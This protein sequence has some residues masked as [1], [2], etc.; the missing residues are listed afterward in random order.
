MQLFKIMAV[1]ITMLFPVA[2]WG[3]EITVVLDVTIDPA[4]GHLS[5]NAHLYGAPSGQVR[6]AVD[7]LENVT[8]DGN[9]VTPAPDDT[10]V[11]ATAVGKST[12]IRYEAAFD[13]AVGQR[14]GNYM[15]ARNVFLMAGW[16]PA[17]REMARYTLSVTLPEGFAAVS[18]AESVTTA[19]AGGLTTHLFR[20]DHPL[21]GLHLAASANYVVNKAEHDGIS[22]ET[23][24]FEKDAALADTYIDATRQYLDFYNSTLT[25]YPYRRFAIVENM[26]PTGYSMPTFTL[27]GKQVVKLPFI[28]KTS[29]AH[30]IVHQWFGNYVYIDHSQGNWAEG[31]TTYLSDYLLEEKKGSGEAYRKRVLVEYDAYVHDDNAMAVRDFHFRGNKAQAAVGYGRA[32]MF[33][34]G[35]RKRYGDGLF[36]D[37]LKDVIR[38]NRF[39]AASW[40]DIRKSF[41]KR[42]GDTLAGYFS[43][44]LERPDIPVLSVSKGGVEIRNGAPVLSFTLQQHTAPFPLKVPIQVYT[45]TGVE[46][47]A[48]TMDKKQQDFSLRLEGLPAKVV[49]DQGNDLMRR[50]T[51][52]EMP[53]VLAHIMGS[54]EL[55]FVVA[56][57]KLP[58][59]QPLVRA[60][61][62]PHITTVAPDALSYARLKE[63]SLVV[64]GHDNPLAASLFG[65]TAHPA[66]TGLSLQ[67]F[68]NPFSQ[69]KR[70]LVVHAAG[71]KETLAVMNNLH[72]YGQYSRLTFQGGRVVVKKT[73]ESA[74]GIVIHRQP[75]TFALRPDR[76]PTLGQILDRLTASRVVYVGERHDRHAHHMNQLEII[77]H[78]YAAGVDLAVG[79][80]MFHQPFQ[81]AVNR[82]LENRTDE[83]TFLRE[84]GYYREWGYDYGLY[85]PIVDFLKENHI[86]LVALNIPGEVS[87]KVAREGIESLD[88]DQRAWIP[89]GL[90]FSNQ[91]YRRDLKQVY[92]LHG[93]QDGINNFDTFL[94]AQVLWDEGMADRAYR[95][96][97]GHPR[98]TLVVLAGNGHLRHGYGIPQR[99]HRRLDAP[100]TVI[101]QD[102]PLEAGIADYV[103]VTSDVKG[104]EA[105]KLGVTVAEKAQG[106]TITG[107]SKNSPAEKAGLEKGDLIR[108]LD[109][110]PVENLADLRLVLFYC[111]KDQTTSIQVER[112]EQ[113]VATEITL[114]EFNA[115]SMHGGK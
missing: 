79:M 16:Y 98:R 26:L 101:V 32:A 59:Y 28:V 86:P 31:L 61:G 76:E 6:L 114:F 103:L 46:T 90:D 68:K 78:L 8:V 65:K 106:L 39:R 49:L 19:S 108:S 50:L 34:H 47:T 115:F 94:Q 113:M 85:K 93:R 88:D 40:T 42:S 43:A 110:Q 105:P 84:S 11:V 45:Q 9:E 95:Y 22:I 1:F 23:Y 24:F 66:D 27:L 58:V 97:E 15:D 75:T 72:H 3:A 2:V 38:S 20:F 96:L 100:F 104:K 112:G 56:A 91:D 82:Y 54:D 51:P 73:D 89:A 83:R 81:D 35:L 12:V 62:N 70:I 57:D 48:V 17:P 7:N 109:E 67:V 74:S 92:D 71:K 30:E 41:E 87:K 77:R 14:S 33:F 69:Y 102:E 111:Q 44:W 63:H 25:P 21:D 13:A 10:V 64:C 99:L 4:A 36:L 52:A 55:V 18:E 107:I 60:L 53:P 37:A 80:E 5:G 29:L